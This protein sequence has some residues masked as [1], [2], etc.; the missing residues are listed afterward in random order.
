MAVE[1]GI[2]DCPFQECE[3]VLQE[4]YVVAGKLLASSHSR[5]N[6]FHEECLSQILGESDG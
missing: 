5:V 3:R 1:R 2:K 4:R 6:Q